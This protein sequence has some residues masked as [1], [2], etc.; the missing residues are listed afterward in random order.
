VSD[1]KLS[2]RNGDKVRLVEACDAKWLGDIE[3][4]V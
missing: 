1:K 3:N 2:I 4:R